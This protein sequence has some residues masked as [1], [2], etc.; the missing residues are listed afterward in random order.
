MAPER[1]GQVLVL[2]QNQSQVVSHAH[3]EANRKTGSATS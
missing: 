2:T 1:R 3:S